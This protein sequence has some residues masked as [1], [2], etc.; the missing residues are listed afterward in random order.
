M[1]YP[2][3]SIIIPLYII[4]GRFFEDFLKFKNLNYNNL[5]ILVVSDKKVILPDLKN[6]DVKVLLTKR[7]QTGPAEKRDLAIKSAKGE[8]CAFIDD[9]A[10]P[11]PNWIKNAVPWFKNPDIVAVGGPGV[12]PFEDAYWAKIGGYIIESYLCSGGMQDRFYSGVKTGFATIPRFVVDWPAYNLIVRTN[13]LKKVG[14]YRST[15]YGGEDTALCLKLIK[16]GRILADTNVIVYHHRREFPLGLL[17]QIANVGL[18]R[19]YFFKKFP[20]TSRSLIYLLPAFLIL[21][22]ITGILLSILNPQIYLLPFVLVFFALWVLASYSI[23]SHKVDLVSS[24]VAG[25]GI[26]LTHITYGLFFIRG[27]ATT[28]LVR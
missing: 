16:R 19:G 22:F 27:L 14:G 5:E 20:E 11:D 25:L 8:F 4:S 26:M 12:T 7:K 9:D 23:F 2:K 28:K 13:I 17:K 15:F 18:H 6:I 24:I 21:G 1:K 10:Y 3:V